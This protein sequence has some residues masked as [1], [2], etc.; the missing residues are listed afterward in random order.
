M[1]ITGREIRNAAQVVHNHQ[2]V[3]GSIGPCDFLLVLSLKKHLANKS[4]SADSNVK[5]TVTSLLHTLDTFF[6]IIILNQQSEYKLFYKL[7]CWLAGSLTCRLISL[8]RSPPARRSCKF[9]HNSLMFGSSYM[10]FLYHTQRRT[11]FR[12]TPLDE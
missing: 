4:F 12:R 11:T 10:R 8:M 3:V 1:K 5:Q 2:A 6:I 7:M 9:N